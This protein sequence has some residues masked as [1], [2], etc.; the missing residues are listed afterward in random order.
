MSIVL[1]SSTL[2]VHMYTFSRTPNLWLADPC[3]SWDPSLRTEKRLPPAN[4]SKWAIFSNCSVC[5][6]RC[7]HTCWWLI[8]QVHLIRSTW[9]LHTFLIHV[10]AIRLYI[11]LRCRTV[12]SLVKVFFSPYVSL[13]SLAQSSLSHITIKRFSW[14]YLACPCGQLWISVKHALR[15]Y[16]LLSSMTTNEKLKGFCLIK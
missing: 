15:N 14:Q 16:Q 12:C 3:G 2:D 6:N 4:S 9:L 10:D 7:R 5:F 8:Y 1:I 13:L 11:V